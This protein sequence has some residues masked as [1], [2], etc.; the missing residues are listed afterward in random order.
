M[1]KW[2]LHHVTIAPLL[3]LNEKWLDEDPEKN[4]VLKYI[5]TFKDRLFRAGQIAKN[6]SQSKMKVWYDRKTKSRCFEP[7]DR[8]LVLFTVVGNPLQVKYTGPYK[9]LR[10]ISDI[11]YL[12]RTLL[13]D[14]KKHKCVLSIC[15][16]HIMKKQ[17]KS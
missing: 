15:S 8:V 4:S 1:R 13:V 16:K 6:V 3:L 2:S 5:A 10:K 14:I 9:R 17:N 12:L 7:G 11:N